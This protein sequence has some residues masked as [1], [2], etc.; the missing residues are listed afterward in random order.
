MRHKIAPNHIKIGV[1]PY[2]SNGYLN[3]LSKLN[4]EKVDKNAYFQ[5]WLEQPR[6]RAKIAPNHIKIAVHDYL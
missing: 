4:F 1:H 2:L 5:S 3:P 6:T